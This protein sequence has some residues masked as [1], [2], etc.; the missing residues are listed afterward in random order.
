MSTQQLQAQL[1][2]PWDRPRDGGSAG[3]ERGGV[4][5]EL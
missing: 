1:P 5:D 3:R 4:C 2:K